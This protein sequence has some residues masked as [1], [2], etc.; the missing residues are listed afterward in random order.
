MG[1][2][3]PQGLQSSDGAGHRHGPGAC[4]GGGEADGPDA[5]ASLGDASR[6]L[7]TWLSECGRT[8]IGTATH[9]VRISYTLTA[10]SGQRATGTAWV[11]DYGEFDLFCTGTSGQNPT[12]S[13]VTMTIAPA[14]V[15]ASG[16]VSGQADRVTVE[17]PGSAPQTVYV[18]FE[19]GFTRF[20][21]RASPAYEKNDVVY[22]KL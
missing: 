5:V 3:Q 9:S 20:R 16:Y 15:A 12:S 13:A 4:G 8:S 1:A 11:T 2:Y 6:Y 17:R 22:R 14:P 19:P 7:G 10:A 21:L 18:A